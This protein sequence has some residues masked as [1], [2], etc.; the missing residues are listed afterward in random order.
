[1]LKTVKARIIFSTLMLSIIGVIGINYY[2]SKT[3]HELS[4]KTTKES[5]TMLSKS[6][7]QTLRQSMFAGDAAV[8]LST[9]DEA[10]KIEGI[11]SLDV[12]KSQAVIDIF[13]PEERFTDDP[14]IRSIFQTK[15]DELIETE[16]THHTIRLLKPLQASGE[17][18]ACHAN[19][20]EGDVLGVMDLVISL[21]ENDAEIASTQTTLL[22]ML[23]LSTVVFMAAATFFFS[24]E[25]INPLDQ[26]RKRIGGLVDGD[27][28]LTKRL[29]TSRENEFAAAAKAVNEFVAMVQETVNQVKK[30]GSDN[31]RIASD[32]TKSSQQIS[33]S[34]DEERQI[35]S[36]T[37]ERTRSIHAILNDTLRITQQTQQNVTAATADLDNAKAS[38]LDLVQ[39]VNS[40]VE[41]ENELSSQLLHL[42][43]D[44]DQVKNVLGVIKDIADQTNLLA[45]NAAIEAARAGEHGRGFAV[46]ADEVRKLAERTSK[47]LVEIEISVNT[48][49]QSINDVSDRMGDNAQNMEKLS[50]VSNDVE[51]K[52]TATARAM[53]ESRE[54]A[55]ASFKDT[56]E[57][58]KHTE[59]I[60][61]KISKINEHSHSNQQRVGAID[62][63]LN[64]LLDVAKSLQARINEFRS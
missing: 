61:D 56:Q 64:R 28:D 15:K 24:N 49:V 46:V 36:E 26:L 16:G 39:D 23:L 50:D 55:E 18:L 63:D 52:I 19:V 40:Y 33:R 32:I 10:S 35:V 5:L 47:S 43:N 51:E 14:L 57:V 45:L 12:I 58:V 42:R 59:W 1:V 53:Y 29:D 48:I 9:V 11:D 41:I 3:L 7:F 2:L 4:N 22:I 62:N 6:I 13:A 44:A 34:I 54:V 20:A 38:L 21:D 30:L 27:K 31:E 25:I 17:C 60:V 37:T 8:V